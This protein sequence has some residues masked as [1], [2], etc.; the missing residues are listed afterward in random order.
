MDM[1]P[2]ADLIAKTYKTYDV[3]TSSY[4]VGDSV[5]SRTSTSYFGQYTDPITGSTV[6]SDFL[7]QYNYCPIQALDTIPL[8]DTASIV[9]IDLEFSEFVGDSLSPVSIEVYEL[10]S[11]LDPNA[12]YY[13]N[14]DPTKF[15]KKDA[16]PVGSLRFSASN[17]ALADTTRQK[18]YSNGYNYVSIPIDRTIGDEILQAFKKNPSLLKEANWCKSGVRG[19]KGFYFKLC[20][21]DGAMFYI[22]NSR[23]NVGF[24]YRDQYT[25]SLYGTALLFEGTEEVVQA[26]RFTSRNIQNLIDDTDATYLK[27]PA[28]VFTMAELPIDSISTNDT[29]NTASIKFTRYNDDEETAGKVDKTYRL[30]VPQ[31]V[32]LV[33]YDEYINGFFESNKLADNVTSYLATF[34]SSSNS[35]EFSNISRLVTTMLREKKNGTATENCNKVLLIPVEAS[36]IKSSTGTSTVVKLNHDFSMKSARLVGG[37]DGGV[38]IELIYSKFLK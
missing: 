9:Y 22:S 1:I 14:I 2:A 26:S 33:R 11:L 4:A 27:C 32:L 34:N 6:K 13:T 21:G 20:S 29:I 38:Q 15:V 36:T 8:N 19:S 24:N 16:K 23:L 31:T 35:Y 28:G 30:G 12:S 5:L 10:D 37:K 18:R 3:K 7:S 17:R 25:D